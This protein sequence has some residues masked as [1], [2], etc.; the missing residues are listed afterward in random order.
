MAVLT[1]LSSKNIKHVKI[2]RYSGS[3]LLNKITKERCRK[4]TD[5]EKD[6]ITD[7]ISYEMMLSIGV[8]KELDNI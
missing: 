3:L 4:L 7:E 1:M 2:N 6:E 8:Y 5:E